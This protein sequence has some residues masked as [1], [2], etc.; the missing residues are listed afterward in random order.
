MSK[1]KVTIA[2]TQKTLNEVST[3]S[4]RTQ[5]AI[6]AF[7]RME[8]KASKMLDEANAMSELD[9]EPIDDAKALEEKYATKGTASVEE[10]LDKMKGELNL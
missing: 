10:E 3:A 8:D 4:E 1:A 7:E 6:E 5:G 9:M 2:K